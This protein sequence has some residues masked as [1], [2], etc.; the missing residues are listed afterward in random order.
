MESVINLI[1]ALMKELLTY[2]WY[3][4]TT[5]VRST[6]TK[7]STTSSQG[8]RACTSGMCA[9]QFKIFLHYRNNVVLK[10]M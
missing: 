4:R 3:D 7:V 9:W 10:V 2:V 5:M 1:M 8:M 6:D